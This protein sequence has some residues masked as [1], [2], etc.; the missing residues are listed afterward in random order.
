MA[1][2][3]HATS[4]RGL[5]CAGELRACAATAHSSAEVPIGRVVDVGEDRSPTAVEEFGPLNITLFT[6]HPHACSCVDEE[7]EE[8]RDGGG[9]GPSVCKLDPRGLKAPRFQ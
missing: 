1:A 5:L 9:G 2:A 8:A 6:H 3:L 7:E 4:M